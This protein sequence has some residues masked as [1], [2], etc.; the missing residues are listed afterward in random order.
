MTRFTVFLGVYAV[1]GIFR[2]V[3]IVFAISGLLSL[4]IITISMLREQPGFLLIGLFPIPVFLLAIIF[5]P[6]IDLSLLPLKRTGS[7]RLKYGISGNS[8]R[9]CSSN[10]SSRNNGLNTSN[11]SLGNNS[12]TST[13]D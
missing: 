1:A 3:G 13:K 6:G 2:T 10:G 4:T 8:S 5:F 9:L 11:S 7:A 12:K